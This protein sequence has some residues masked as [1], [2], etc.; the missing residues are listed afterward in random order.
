MRRILGNIA[1]MVGVFVIMFLL[2]EGAWRLTMSSGDMQRQYDPRVGLVNPPHAEWTVR[3]PEF[4]TRMH[5]NAL[6]F[7]GP[8]LAPRVD[9]QELRVLFL[10]DSFVEEKPVADEERF[11]EQTATLLSKELS[12]PV[13]ARALA[14]G[15]ANPGRELL[16]YREYGRSFDPD[17]VVQVLFLENDLFTAS[18]SFAFRRDASG[19]LELTEIRPEPPPVC[20]FKCQLLRRSE[21]LVQ[22]YRLVR[23][24]GNTEGA[25]SLG[26]LVGYTIIGQEQYE[27]EGRFDV[28]RALVQALRNDVEKD[29]AVFVTVLM[30]AGFEIEEEWSKEIREEVSTVVPS[31]GWR[32]SWLLNTGK[33]VLEGAGIRVL[34]LRPAIA[35]Q[36]NDNQHLYWRINGHLNAVGSRVVA[37]A[38]TQ[39]LRG[40]PL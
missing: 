14:V 10:G 34:D 13:M 20:P 22:I 2:M 38:L 16:F 30:P 4:V 15:G 1:L 37:E 27:T 31:D 17:I 32:P 35:A 25:P 3:T 11:V 9:P 24:R 33:M 6:G 18:G 29:G 26:D 36:T 7:R 5:T 23:G 28:L 21:V 39:Y 8:E 12:R 19:A 40:L